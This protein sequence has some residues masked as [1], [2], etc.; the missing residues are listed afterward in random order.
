MNPVHC[1]YGFFVAQ[2]EDGVL[3][4]HRDYPDG[5]MQVVEDLLSS[6]VAE[7]TAF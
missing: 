6:I 3:I 4:G 1:P 5:P 2:T 7:A